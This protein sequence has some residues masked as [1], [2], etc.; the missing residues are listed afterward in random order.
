VD[1]AIDADP[2]GRR[3]GLQET[4]RIFGFQQTLHLRE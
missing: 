4:A 1:H 2:L 3:I